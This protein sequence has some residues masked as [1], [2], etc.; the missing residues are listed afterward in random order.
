MDLF[1]QLIENSNIPIVTSILI[2]IMATISPCNLTT[3]LAAIAYLSK[4]YETKYNT[5]FYILGRILTF[6]IIGAI[7]F[8]SKN[9]FAI[10]K[11]I[12]VNGSKLFGPFLFILGLF[13]LDIIKFPELKFLNINYNPDSNKKNIYS[14]FLMGLFFALAFCPYSAVLFFGFVVPLSLGS[15]AGFLNI[16]LYAIASSIIVIIFSV[17][18]KYTVI[19]TKKLFKNMNKIDLLL[20]KIIGITFLII[21]CYYILFTTLKINL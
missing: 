17:L 12:Q 20:R 13:L 1:N 21:G 3:N 6:T 4:D 10:S 11:F 5:L 8:L 7:L 9:T 18:L 2:G 19:N 14:A 16:I 15:K